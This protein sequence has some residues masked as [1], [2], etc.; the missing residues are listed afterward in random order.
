MERV[1]KGASKRSSSKKSRCQMPG[2]QV[3]GLVLGGL[4]PYLLCAVHQVPP[5]SGLRWSS[6]IVTIQHVERWPVTQQF[7]TL[8]APVSECVLD[9]A[10]RGHCSSRLRAKSPEEEQDCS[11]ARQESCTLEQSVY[12][13]SVAAAPLDRMTGVWHQTEVCAYI[14]LETLTLS[15]V[16]LHMRLLCPTSAILLCLVWDKLWSFF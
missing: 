8:F 2:D 13:A 10:G 16:S 14:C 15:V 11:W 5:L 6:L 7:L 1:S 4:S 12:L 9:G 3:Q